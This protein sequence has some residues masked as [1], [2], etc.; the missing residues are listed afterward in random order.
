MPPSA[1]IGTPHILEGIVDVLDGRD[2]RHADAGDDA[3]GADR[4]RADADLDAV[5]AV[6]D[7][8]QRR[9]GGGDVAADHLDAREVL[10]DPLDAVEHALRMAVRGIDD[11]DIDAGL[12][13]Q[14]DAFFGARADADGGAGTQASGSVL[15]GVRV[16]GGL[17]DVLDGDQAAQLESV[18]DDHHAFEAVL[19][20]HR[21]AFLDGGPFGNRH[22]SMLWRHDIADRLVEFGFE[23]Q[24]AVGDDADDHPAIEYRYAGDLVQSG[25]RQHVTHRHLWGHGNRI[26]EDSG[27]E[28]LDLGDFGRLP[29]RAEVLVHDS[30]AAF[31][32]QGD[33]QARLGHGVHGRR[34]ERQVEADV[35]RQTRLERDVARHYGRMGGN[36]EHVVE[37]QRP[38][39]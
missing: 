33:G 38:L 14:F 22:Q 35:A 13:E 19:V 27:F 36:E 16:F 23:A 1:I 9:F 15:A 34:N 31:L 4:A 12:G 39:D 21:L 6:I 18:V 30:D 24:V 7:H 32:R 28:T 3:R 29:L 5:G 17:D 25:Q 11:Q 26:L 37:R 2:L 10:L 8:R 20:D